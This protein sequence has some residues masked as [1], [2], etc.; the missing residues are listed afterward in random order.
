MENPFL[1]WMIW[2]YHHLRKHP[3]KD[4]QSGSHHGEPD[5]D[6]ARGLFPVGISAMIMKEDTQISRWFWGFFFVSSKKTRFSSSKMMMPSKE[7]WMDKNIRVQVVW[8][9]CVMIHTILALFDIWLFLFIC[10]TVNCT[11]ISLYFVQ[12]FLQSFRWLTQRSCFV[13]PGEKSLR[14]HH[15]TPLESEQMEQSELMVYF[16]GTYSPWKFGNRF[17]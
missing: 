2:G 17:P 5:C 8:I 13:V 6:T 11:E 12:T 7:L 16:D 1:E 10:S 9:I 4:I 14:K 3:Y 15:R